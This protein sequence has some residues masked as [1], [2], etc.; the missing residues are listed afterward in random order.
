MVPF[1]AHGQSEQPFR[2]RLL[3]DRG[4]VQLVEEQTLTPNRLAAAID[5]AAAT[6]RPPPNGI[7]L[8]GAQRSAALL[9]GL[10]ES[11]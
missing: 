10:L 8:D 1:G 7:K 6:A 4:W 2:A 11:A 9:A 3:A 5:R